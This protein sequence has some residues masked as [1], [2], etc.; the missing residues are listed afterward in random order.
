M[1]LTS[2]SFEHLEFGDGCYINVSLSENTEM[3]SPHWHTEAEI[4]MPTEGSYLVN[5]NGYYEH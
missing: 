5:I 1:K 4:I 2:D 3:F